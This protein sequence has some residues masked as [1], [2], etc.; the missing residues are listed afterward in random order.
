M[1]RLT[2]TCH[3]ETALCRGR[4]NFPF[5]VFGHKILTAKLFLC[6]SFRTYAEA[7]VKYSYS[8]ELRDTGRHGFLLPEDEILPSS[9]ETMAGVMYLANFIRKREK[10]WGYMV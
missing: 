1:D 10:Q 6:Y 5:D 8:V 7:N 3:L 2:G 9:E 4:G